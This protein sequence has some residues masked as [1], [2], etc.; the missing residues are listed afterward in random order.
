[1]YSCTCNYTSD[2]SGLFDPGKSIYRCTC[3]NNR[4]QLYFLQ[5]Q[6]YFLHM[7]L[8][9]FTGAPVYLQ[10]HLYIFIAAHVSLVFDH[11]RTPYIG[12]GRF[13]PHEIVKV[14]KNNVKYEEVVKHIMQ[15]D[16]LIIDEYKYNRLFPHGF[17]TTISTRSPL[18]WRH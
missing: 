17:Q 14:I 7:R 1:M 8:Y 15:T 9:F 2:W 12:D 18:I 5:V 3:I 16:V 6:L 4:L 11:V 13:G 10:V